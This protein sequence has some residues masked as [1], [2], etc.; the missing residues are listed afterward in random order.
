M[1]DQF[2]VDLHVSINDFRSCGWREILVSKPRIATESPYVVFHKASEQAAGE[3]RLEH[4]KILALLGAACSMR[5]NPRNPE[6]PFLPVW[7]SQETRSAVPEDFH[8][9]DI[10]LFSLIVAEMEEP[11]VKARL[12][13]LVHFRSSQDKKRFAELAI[14][15]YR[16]LPLD[17]ETWHRGGREC[18]TRGLRLAWMF[19]KGD[20]GRFRELEVTILSAFEAAGI[21]EKFFAIRMAELLRDLDLGKA[22]RSQITKKLKEFGDGF[23]DA[24][25]Q[26]SAQ[27]Y[28]HEAMAWFHAGKQTKEKIEM[29]VRI[30]VSLAVEAEKC[31]S[32]GPN[33]ALLAVIKFGNAIEAY[34]DIPNDFREKYQVEERLQELRLGLSAA[35]QQTVQSLERVQLPAVDLTEEVQAATRAVGGKPFQEALRV[36]TS[37]PSWTRT[38]L[39]L[40]DIPEQNP[41]LSMATETIFSPDGRVVASTPGGNLCR[42]G[43]EQEDLV[44]GE[45]LFQYG[46]F[47]SL[48]VEAK[49]RP[50]ME[51]IRQEH[52]LQEAYFTE[53]AQRSPIV[54]KSRELALG[55]VFHYGFQQDF[56]TAIHL[57]VPQVEHMV[58]IHL[59]NAGETTTTLND[60]GTETEKGLASLLRLPKADTHLG[61]DL[62]FELRALFC[63]PRG[64]NLRNNVAHGL[65]GVAECYTPHAIYAWWRMLTLVCN[66][67]W[68][69]DHRISGLPLQSD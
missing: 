40:A 49:L 27:Q 16:R 15:S 22:K 5:L 13:D 58:R 30:A 52:A 67:A 26:A 24:G 21:E 69:E 7:I 25:D 17:A 51:V 4:A 34:R 20:G 57:L 65:L 48:V 3:G 42:P 47:V 45:M 50:A 53:I 46:I 6:N 60:D 11:W 61:Q 8:G 2:Q 62:A 36:F 35:G 18:W 38:G 59:K 64:P 37:F 68:N 32:A 29:Q 56:I 12:A 44:S 43:S 31:L 39:F 9:D 63:D 28:Y 41:W 10:S 66:A 23:R 14:D 54:P 19:K 33:S 55:K 1:T